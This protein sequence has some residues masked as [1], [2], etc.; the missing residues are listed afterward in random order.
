MEPYCQE[1]GE[2]FGADWCSES[3]E[4]CYVDIECENG[5]DTLFFADTEY[6]DTLAY[7]PT[8][9]EERQAAA[10]LRENEE[11]EQLAAENFEWEMY[12]VP[13]GFDGLYGYVKT[14]DILFRKL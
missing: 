3:Y 12:L 5:I 7:T 1:G 4:W 9:C 6:A 2:N 11:A 14:D 8:T 10:Q 13:N